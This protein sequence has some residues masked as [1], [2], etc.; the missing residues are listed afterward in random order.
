MAD[1]TDLLT[2]WD[3]NFV[4]IN[5]GFKSTEP[6]SKKKLTEDDLTSAALQAIPSLS[7]EGARNVLPMWKKLKAKQQL[8]EL[9]RRNKLL[10]QPTQGRITQLLFRNYKI[11]NGCVYKQNTRAAGLVFKRICVCGQGEDT[12]VVVDVICSRIWPKLYRLIHKKPYEYLSEWEI[13][14]YRRIGADGQEIWDTI[15]PKD[16]ISKTWSAYC[17]MTESH[18]PPIQLVTNQPTVPS[19]FFFDPAKV[20][21]THE[22]VAWHAFDGQMGEL[23]CYWRAWLYSIFVP[24]NTARQAMW[25]HDNGFAGKSTVCRVLFNILGPDVAGTVSKNAIDEKFIGAALQ[26]KHLLLL[27]DTK[28]PTILKHGVMHSL[29][30]GDVAAVEYKGED[31]TSEVLYAKVLIGANGPP[32]ITSYMASEISRVLCIELRLLPGATH[33]MKE[34]DGSISYEGNNQFESDLKI[35]FWSYLAE[36]RTEYEKHCKNN[37]NIR[38]TVGHKAM[39][40]GGIYSD[41]E[42]YIGDFCSRIVEITHK[43][44]DTITDVDLTN[45]SKKFASEFDLNTWFSRDLKGYLRVNGLT[46][47]RARTNGKPLRAWSGIKFRTPQEQGK[48]F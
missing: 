6:Y 47:N 32:D 34:S 13:N 44:E 4:L 30:G 26:G 46:C 3:D 12:A 37:G 36:C 8:T 41:V 17:S 29:L 19:Y 18:M 9:E 27:P 16:F 20:V 22:P 40:F 2:F 31:Q 5:D 28:D 48:K 45:A 7:L 38:V 21:Y 1:K 24:E 42:I 23:A 14:Q 43:L 35:Q 25:I 33:I 39:M 11:S 10:R 15:F